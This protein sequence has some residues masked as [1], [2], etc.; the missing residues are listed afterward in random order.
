MGDPVIQKAMARPG[1]IKKTGG[2]TA[3]TVS[4]VLPFVASQVG[5]VL[6]NLSSLRGIYGLFYFSFEEYSPCRL[7][8]YSTICWR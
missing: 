4:F 3:P 2:K 5:D 7:A 6:I 1:V 8:L